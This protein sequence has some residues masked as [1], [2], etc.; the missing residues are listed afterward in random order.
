MPSPWVTR[1]ITNDLP[2]QAYAGTAAAERVEPIPFPHHRQACGLC[3]AD[4]A[5]GDDS[6]HACACDDCT[7]ILP[8]DHRWT[9]SCACEA[10]L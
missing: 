9:D 6:P 7:P 1:A 3:W 5:A 10:C 8:G 2:A 4:F